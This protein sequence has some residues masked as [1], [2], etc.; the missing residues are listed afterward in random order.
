MQRIILAVLIGTLVAFAAQ[1]ATLGKVS[2]AK[3]DAV[4]EF[5][6]IQGFLT[7]TA[8][9]T[10]TGS[11]SMAFTLFDAASGGSN[12]WTS[13]SESV[14]VTHGL[15]SWELGMSQALF[16]TGAERWLEVAVDGSP[17]LPRVHITSA[18]FAY[19]STKSDTADYAQTSTPSG[20]AGGDLSG[21]YPNPTVTRLQGR[22][23]SASAP[24]TNQVLKWN[25][26]TWGPAND[27]TGGSVSGDN[28]WVRVG[29]DSVLYT[30]HR[31]GLARGGAG[32]VLLGSSAATHVNFGVGCTTG[33]STPGFD[34]C[35]YTVGGGK[36]N[37]ATSIYATVAGGLSNRAWG[38][39]AAI[40]G[41][42]YNSCASFSVIAGGIDNAATVSWATVGGGR[43]D[44]ASANYATVGG[45]RQNVASGTNSTASGGAYNI[46]SGRSAAVPGGQS[47][48]AAG[49][50]SFATNQSSSA[51]NSNS[52]AFNGTTTN[53]SNQTSVSVLKQGFGTFACDHPLDPDAKILNQYV[54]GS[55]EAIMTYRGVAVLGSDG[56]GEARLPDYFDALN[57]NPMIQLTGVG[58]SDVVYV[59]EEEVNNRFLI[60]GKPGMKVF[61]TVT[62]ERKDPTA[63]IGRALQPVEMS[64]TGS[65]RGVSLDDATLVGAMRQLEQ[66]G[67]SGKFHFR[68][69]AARRRYEDMLRVSREVGSGLGR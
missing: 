4:P 24:G 43:G 16:S 14:Q 63:E 20:S 69:E 37:S 56:K 35:G 18:P 41:G 8:G 57:R 32:N 62:G 1:P 67:L 7:A 6:N 60:G 51:P 45:G 26:S 44:T 13:G 19:H 30:I 54:A 48:T 33:T 46:V 40:G 49:D 39:V 22:S 11:R 65:L 3:T 31:L 66:M 5:V 53:A 42:R 2:I 38:D 68:T 50:Y 10:I 59:A 29:G 9:D 23:V 55:N 25:G 47:C 34:T 28:A 15:F 64:K 21:T 58:S 36:N 12:L 27:S 52:A 61:W 17:L